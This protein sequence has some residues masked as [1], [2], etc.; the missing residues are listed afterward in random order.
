MI[1]VLDPDVHKTH[2]DSV[3]V[4]FAAAT[5]KAQ[6]AQRAVANLVLRQSLE[7]TPYINGTD[8]QLDA[9]TDVITRLNSN[10]PT[11]DAVLASYDY[12]D[13]TKVTAAEVIGAVNAA[14]NRTGMKLLH[15]TYL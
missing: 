14:G 15:D 6:L 2:V 3:S 8:Y 10:I 11:D 13:P 12:A 1:N 5:G 4:T 7:T 9:Q